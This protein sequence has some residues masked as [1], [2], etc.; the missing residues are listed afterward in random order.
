M[1]CEREE[2][3][4]ARLRVPL[5][6]GGEVRDVHRPAL[7]LSQAQQGVRLGARALLQHHGGNNNNGLS[8]ESKKDA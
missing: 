1:L 5:H 4:R 2:V 8:V 3:D 6:Q 7:R